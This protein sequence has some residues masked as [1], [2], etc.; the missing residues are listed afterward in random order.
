MLSKILDSPTYAAGSTA[1][2]VLYDEDHPVPNL[3][4]APTAKPGPN[5]DPGAGHAAALKTWDQM[6]G[7]PAIQQPQIDQ[8]VSLRAP[9]HI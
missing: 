5:T 6:L 8:A 4:I 2:M 9:A 7:L 3:I 1:V